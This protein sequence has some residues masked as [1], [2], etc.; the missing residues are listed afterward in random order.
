MGNVEI[1]LSKI[2]DVNLTSNIHEPIVCRYLN[3]L[4]L[5]ILYIFFEIRIVFMHL[6]MYAGYLYT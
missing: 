3:I 1:L 4:S 2:L 5:K 6:N